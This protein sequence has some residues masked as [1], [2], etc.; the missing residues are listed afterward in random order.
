MLK[1][2][3]VVALL[4]A[5]P[6]A[7]LAQEKGNPARDAAVEEVLKA[8]REE[9][10]AYA[11]RDLA[12]VGRMVAD[13]FVLTIQGGDVGNKANLMT[14]LREEPPDPTLAV[15]T[16]DTQVRVDGDTAVVVGRRVER[17]RSPDN[18][19]EGVAY[20][21]YTRTYVK[22]RGR[23]QLL[24]EHIQA[25]PA[26]RTPVKVDARVYDDYVGR[27]SSDIFTFGVVREGDR[28]VV[29]PDDRR[30]P[31]GEVLPE[32]ESEFFVRGGTSASSSCATAAARSLTRSSSSTARTY[33]RGGSTARSPDAGL[34]GASVCRGA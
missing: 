19:R 30:R 28:L 6:L 9:R 29:V 20:A 11:R 7:A 16:E 2:V 24:A 23:W 3:L 31:R 18:G 22:R 8:E 17:R 14:F 13:E 12:A 15:T 27:Y 10:D 26:E 21:R 33:A 25:V 34:S 1:S 32:S 5:A 4:A